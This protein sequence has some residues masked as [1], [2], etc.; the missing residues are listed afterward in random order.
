VNRDETHISHS[1]CQVMLV[2]RRQRKY[3]ARDISDMGYQ[4]GGEIMASLQPGV[5]HKYAK[6]IILMPSHNVHVRYMINV[7]KMYI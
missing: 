4:P 3:L 5:T 6:T 7:Q 2:N 1:T